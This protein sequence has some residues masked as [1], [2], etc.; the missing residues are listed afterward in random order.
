V[1][2][3]Q[4]LELWVVWTRS[5]DMRVICA[6]TY[7]HIAGYLSVVGPTRRGALQNAKRTGTFLM[8]QL[9]ESLVRPP[10]FKEKTAQ[11]YTYEVPVLLGE[12]PGTVRRVLAEMMLAGTV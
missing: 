9:P 7:R 12:N 2:L 8:S 5:I 4:Y 6:V 11:G 1:F 3:H 10:R